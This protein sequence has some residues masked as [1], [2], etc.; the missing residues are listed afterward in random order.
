[1]ELIP[2]IG[3]IDADSMK[4]NELP[5]VDP[6]LLALTTQEV[7]KL[8]AQKV[9]EDNPFGAHKK[10]T[11]EVLNGMLAISEAD[12]RIPDLEGWLKKRNKE[13]KWKKKL[14]ENEG[15]LLLAQLV[16]LMWIVTLP[17]L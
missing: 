14:S 7:I 2:E 11:T 5:N 15:S 12:H 10:R 8:E 17:L 3:D 9:A 4:V 6:R 1:M 13:G 16:T